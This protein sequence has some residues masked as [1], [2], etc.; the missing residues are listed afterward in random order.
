M[1]AQATEHMTDSKPSMG[2]IGLGAMGGH[3]IVSLLR[4]GYSIT[5]FDIDEDRRNDAV[6]AGAHLANTIEDVVARGQV[7]ATSLPSSD[8]FVQVAE[9]HL[10]PVV[11]AGQTVIDFGTVTPPETRRLAALF[12]EKDVDLID[13]PVSGGPRGARDARLYIFVGGPEEAV[14][15][16]R[17]ILEAVGGPDRLTYC[18]PAGNGQ[19][20]KGVNQLMMGLMD[21]AIL[22][23]IS[24]GVNAGVDADV[25]VRAI[26]DEGRWRQD[27][28]AVAQRVARGAGNDVGVKFRELPYFLREAAE[29]GF[30][31]P[32]TQVVRAFCDKGERI[33]V[34]DHRDAPSYWHELT[35]G[36]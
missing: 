15:R 9:Q 33:T 32:I 25:I 30:E 24:F 26:G 29:Q 5:G 27:F 34:D 36:R 22:E 18:G 19:V 14:A 13:S 31:L 8:A 35:H 20:L 10:L 28:N 6:A 2:F 3:M 12:A 7:I 23:A 17:P 16:C 1:T 4:A 11:R 21:A